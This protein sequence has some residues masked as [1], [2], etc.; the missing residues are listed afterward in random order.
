MNNINCRMKM[1]RR[2]LLKTTDGETVEGDFIAVSCRFTFC[3]QKQYGCINIQLNLIIGLPRMMPQ[4]VATSSKCDQIR[5][6]SRADQVTAFNRSFSV[7][8]HPDN[9]E[10]NNLKDKYHI[11]GRAKMGGIYEN[12]HLDI[13]HAKCAYNFQI[14]L[15]FSKWIFFQFHTKQTKQLAQ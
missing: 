9:Q 13:S 2:R 1:H 3:L 8:F 7:V 5:N 10:N 15:S 6:V 14:F 12:I 4:I 11:Y